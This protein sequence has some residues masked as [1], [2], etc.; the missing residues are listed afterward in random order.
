[1]GSSING[2]F[3][4]G[5]P[6]TTRFVLARHGESEGN[7]A[8]IFQGRAEYALSELGRAQAAALGRSLAK[9]RPARVY[10]SPLGRARETAEIA[11]RA[12]GLSAP[13]A[14][15]VLTE[16]ETGAFT[17]QPWDGVKHRDADAWLA[18]RTRSW[19]GVAGAERSADLYRRA[20]E[21]WATLRDAAAEA[22]EAGELVE[23]G[24][25]RSAA[26]IAV[27][28][29]GF[30]QWLVRVTFGAQS[31]FPLLPIENCCTYALRVEPVSETASAL[32]WESMGERVG[33]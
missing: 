26:V 33:E 25:K 30:L 13:V 9:Y 15:P 17:S 2:A 22:I 19:E 23:D 32:F 27:T 3:F 6:V 1:M 29:G 4:A 31:W 5:L 7:A 12:A 16:L 10:C 14:V 18:F 21:A 11:A 24:G 20:E 8:G 28:H